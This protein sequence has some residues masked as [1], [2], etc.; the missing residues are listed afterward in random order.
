MRTLSNAGEAS[1]YN[2]SAPLLLITR[3]SDVRQP[4]QSIPAKMGGRH[5]AGQFI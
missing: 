4:G 5:G 2:E 1:V 3:L